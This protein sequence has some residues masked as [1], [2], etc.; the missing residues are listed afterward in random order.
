MK[1]LVM[2]NVNIL[3]NTEEFSYDNEPRA[4]IYKRLNPMMNTEEEMKKLLITNS[5]GSPS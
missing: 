1:S 3:S 2:P 5:E 4:F